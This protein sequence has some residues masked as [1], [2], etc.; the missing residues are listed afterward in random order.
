MAT[1]PDELLLEP[2][3][4][5]Q[6]CGFSVVEPEQNWKDRVHSHSFW[7]MNLCTLGEAKIHFDRCTQTVKAGDVIVVPPRN[8]H[9]LE[10]RGGQRFGC[11]SF[12]FDLLGTGREHRAA[13]VLRDETVE[14]RQH[15]LVSAVEQVFRASFPEELYASQLEFCVP[16]G[17]R[18]VMLMEDMLYGM[19]RSLFFVNAAEE[20]HGTLLLQIWRFI[21]ERNGAP[22]S[23]AELAEHLGYSEG[24]LLL[25]IRNATGKTTK[26]LIDEERIRVAKRFLRYSEWNVNLL[27]EHMGFS[28][29]I[30]FIKFFKKYVGEPPGAYKRRYRD[31]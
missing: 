13:Q 1:N 22:V 23:V 3:L 12:K 4:K 10:Y 25:L 27:A 16:Q 24:H 7:Q 31:C 30:Y 9:W 21:A 28:D 29:V 15:E 26:Q 14:L 18:Y 17:A 11:Y 5:L 8:L 20:R 2:R 19:L 6:L